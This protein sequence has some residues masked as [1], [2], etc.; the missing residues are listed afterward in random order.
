MTQLKIDLPDP[1]FQALQMEAAQ[2]GESLDTLVVHYL[3]LIKMMLIDKPVAKS[4]WPDGF[5][6]RTA[7]SWEG[8]PLE[9]G[10][11]GEYEERLEL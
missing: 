3:S 9:R 6:E 2:R 1:V 10:T 11:Q 5:F 4:Q 8:E 7:G